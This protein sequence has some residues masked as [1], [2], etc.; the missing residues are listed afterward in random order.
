M[1]T[2]C[3]STRQPASARCS[4]PT[5]RRT[6]PSCSSPDREVVTYA[7]A[8][9]LVEQGAALPRRRGRAARDR[10]APAR[11]ERCATT[12]TRVR[13][14]ELV[15][16]PREASAVI[17]PDLAD[18]VRGQAR[19]D[20]RRSRLHRLEP[21]ARAGRDGG[22]R[23]ARSTRWSP[24]YGGLLYNVAGHRGPRDGQH[25]GRPR[26]AQPPL[27]RPRPGL[28]LQPRRPDEPP[29][30]DD[31]P[32]HRPRDQ[33]AQ[34]ALDPRGVPAREPGREDRVR[35][36]APDLRAPA[37]PAGRREPSDRAGR[38]QRH[39]QDGG[40]VVPPALRRRLRHADHACSG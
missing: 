15:R 8:D 2:T 25:L 39:Q 31:R 22:A 34:P 5:R 17:R 13:M 24:E 6:S 35:E 16:D 37:A 32:V 10:R 23:R 38:R 29:R 30:L 20:H 4:S 3:G 7:S 36:H 33:R 26:R 21:R 27:P 18:V 40:R 1:R 12:P 28:P 14:R 9:E 11:R 19:A